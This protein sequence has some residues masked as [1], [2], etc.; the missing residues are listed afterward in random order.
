MQLAKNAGISPE[1]IRFDTAPV[2][3]QAYA[4]ASANGYDS[5]A[6]DAAADRSFKASD[7]APG[8]G[9]DVPRGQRP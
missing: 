2:V 7:Y 3:I 9:W 5:K 1:T 8:S 6:A 4:N